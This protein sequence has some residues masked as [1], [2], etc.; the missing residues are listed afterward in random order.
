MGT[1][2]KGSLGPSSD[3]GLPNPV[4]DRTCTDPYPSKHIYHSGGQKLDRS[5]SSGTACKT[6]SSFCF[7]NFSGREQSH[8]LPFCSSQKRWGGGAPAG[9][10]P[11]PLN[12]LLPYKHFQME[13]INMLKDLLRIAYLDGFLIMEETRQ[14]ALQ[15]AATTLNLLEGLGFVVNYPK[16]L[17]IPSQEIE[18]LG[19]IVNSLNL[20][21]SLPKDKIK[22]VRQNCQKLLDNPVI[23][24]RKLA[25]FL[26]LLSASIQAVFPAPLHYRYLQHA[27]NSVLKQ[28]KSY[29]ALVNL[30]P[31]ALQEVQWWRE[32]LTAWN[33]KALL[34]QSTDL[35]S[36]TDA[37]LQGWGAHCQGISTG[38][39]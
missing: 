7:I 32:N 9:H 15:H 23:I 17:L 11:K 28:Q 30:D 31:E 25:K 29:E 18:F 1:N 36:E 20:S 38:R 10:K 3:S 22:K 21:L 27:K 8:Q 26:G 35:T 5:G 39:R 24:V 16:S 13:S 4:Y 34:H 33:E 37:S 12:S 6:S 19:Y 2:N 14:L